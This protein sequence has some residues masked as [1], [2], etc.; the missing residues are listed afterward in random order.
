MSIKRGVILGCVML[1]M[2]MGVF[3]FFDSALAQFITGSSSID[4]TK[5]LNSA[6]ALETSN[7]RNIAQDPRVIAAIVIR[8]FL[9]LLGTILLILIVMSGYWYFTARGDDEKITRAQTTIKQALA[10]M[11]I[12]LTAYAV[13]TYT[14]NSLSTTLKEGDQDHARGEVRLGDLIDAIRNR[15]RD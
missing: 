13:A 7:V 15:K 1:S 8:Y 11:I 12:I 5:Q 9:S 2:S 3:C 10:G 6:G 4:A 14:I